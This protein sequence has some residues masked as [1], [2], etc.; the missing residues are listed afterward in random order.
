MNLAITSYDINKQRFIL[1]KVD[2]NTLTLSQSRRMDA[3]RN[4]LSI[5]SNYWSCYYTI[6]KL[7][8][9][10]FEKQESL[11]FQFDQLLE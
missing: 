3:L 9:F 8:L 5:L 2:V 4:Y 11:S 10:D 7:T 6:R 1:G